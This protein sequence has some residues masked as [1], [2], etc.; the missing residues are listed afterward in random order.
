MYILDWKDFFNFSDVLFCLHKTKSVDL[1]N[2]YDCDLYKLYTDECMIL[3][4]IVWKWTFGVLG[5]LKIYLKL[6]W[7]HKATIYEV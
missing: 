6:T 7:W 5:F 3:W 2:D 4:L 1:I